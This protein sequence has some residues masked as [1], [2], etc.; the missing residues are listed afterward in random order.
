M[1]AFVQDD[2]KV[3]PN[4]TLNLGL[5]W[6]DYFNPSDAQGARGIDN[7]VFPASGD[8]NTRIAKAKMVGERHLLNHTQS[9]FSPRA[10]FAWDPTRAGKM[11]VRGG[12]GIFYDRVSNQLFDGG[13]TNTPRFAIA[14]ANIN[15][16]GV[17]PTS[18]WVLPALRHIISASSGAAGGP[19]S[20]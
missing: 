19:G 7:I 6:D 15:T 10:A 2:W 11:S 8:W 9:L 4:L 17:L 1:S 3:K 20:E 14:S 18:H 16:P 13:F 5:R 12:F